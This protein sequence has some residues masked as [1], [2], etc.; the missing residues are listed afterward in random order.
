MGSFLGI[1]FCGG[2]GVRLGKITEYIS[3]AFVPVYDRPVFMYPLAQL[4]ASKQIDEIVIL[5]NE[6]N[7]AKLR[8]TGHRTIIQDDARV[9]DMLSGLAYIREIT[10]DRRPAVLMPCDNVS[11]IRV[12]DVVEMFLKEKPDIAISIRRVELE[13]KLREMGV[14]DPT[15]GR[16]QYRPVKPKSNWGVIAPYVVREGL[17]ITGTEL[18][19]LNRC[20]ISY[21]NYAGKWFDVGDV[22]SLVRSNRALAPKLWADEEEIQ[23]P[24]GRQL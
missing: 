21:V 23:G 22:K 19:I 9:H 17:R 15:T 4:E 20:R 13:A 5:T 3:K 14:F 18:E 10:G 24:A 7:D 11:D 2:R 12:D 6:D 1:L 8:R 16:I